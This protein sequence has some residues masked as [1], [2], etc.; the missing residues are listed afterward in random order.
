MAAFALYWF[1]S[2]GGLVVATAAIMT[3]LVSLFFASWSYRVAPGRLTWLISGPWASGCVQLKR[4]RIQTK[5]SLNVGRS[6]DNASH[7][8]ASDDRP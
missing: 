8:R 3:C 7:R 2:L 5:S 4:K 1:S 6:S